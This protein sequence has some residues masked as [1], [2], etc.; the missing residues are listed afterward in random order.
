MDASQYQQI[1]EFLANLKSYYL[2]NARHNMPWRLNTSPYSVLI[3]EIMLQQ[4]Q[5]DRVEP[6]YQRFM[7]ELPDFQALANTSTKEIIRLWQG[8]GYNRR[9]LYL[10]QTA[11]I[12]VSNYGGTLPN[13][14][15]SLE[16]LPGIGPST[17]GAIV[18]Y[19][20]NQ[21]IVFIETNIRRVL[22]HHFF[23]DQ[24]NIL[25]SQIALIL[26]T[27]LPKLQKYGFTTQSFY[28]AMMDYGTYLKGVVTNPNR[29]SKHYTKQSK[30][31][32]SDRQLRGAIIQKLSQAQFSTN[33]ELAILATTKNQQLN[34]A[35]ILT[36]LEEEGFIR[37]TKEGISLR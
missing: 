34:F 31:A 6:K 15:A 17:S 12:V 32:G 24:T 9:A 35:R 14:R 20:F 16:S 13:D 8:L 7:T 2:A 19:S 11:K 3:S 1:S 27:I 29:N 36:S 23:A 26:E 25:D 10:Q 37:S 21:P 18:A 30:F 33:E 28:W 22:I 5:V 4:T